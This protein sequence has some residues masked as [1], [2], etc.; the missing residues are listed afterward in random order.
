MAKTLLE[1]IEEIKQHIPH[2]DCDT[3][4]VNRKKD[5]GL[6]IDVREPS[7]HETE[8]VTGAINIPRGILEMKMLTLE[9][10]RSRPIYL[11]CA[12]AVARSTECGTT[13]QSGVYPPLC[14]DG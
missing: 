8:S 12:S 6:L 4:A 14:G 13:A 11:H 2:F 7:E 3:A 9:P 5:N 1:I 10:N